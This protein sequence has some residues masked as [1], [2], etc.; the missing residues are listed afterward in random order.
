MLD[1][2]IGFRS[3]F[4]KNTL[5]PSQQPHKKHSTKQDQNQPQG[6]NN[7]PIKGATKL[8]LKKN[9]KSH[10]SRQNSRSTTPNACSN[11]ERQRTERLSNGKTSKRVD[12]NITELN[13]SD[14]DYFFDNFDKMFKIRETPDE[15]SS[16]ST[17]PTKMRNIRRI[18]LDDFA[19]LPSMPFSCKPDPVN[20]ERFSVKIVSTKDKVLPKLEELVLK[21]YPNAKMEIQVPSTTSHM[22]TEDLNNATQE[23][24]EDMAKFELSSKTNKEKLP[25]LK[26]PKS[27]M[28][29][30]SSF[31]KLPN[32][33]TTRIV[34]KINKFHENFITK[35]RVKVSLTSKAVANLDAAIVKGKKSQQALQNLLKS[36]KVEQVRSK[37]LL[38]DENG[39][40]VGPIQ[41]EDV[42]PRGN[43]VQNIDNSTRKHSLQKHDLSLDLGNGSSKVKF[44]LKTLEQRT[45]N[46]YYQGILNKINGLKDPK[47]TNA[48]SRSQYHKENLSIM[49]NS[50]RDK[51]LLEGG[52][53]T[54]K[55]LRD[56]TNLVP[57]QQNNNNDVLG[58][59]KSVKGQ[60]CRVKV[61]DIHVGQL[62]KGSRGSVTNN[63]KEQSKPTK[64][65]RIGVNV[66]NPLKE[67]GNISM[68]SRSTSVPRR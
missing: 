28:N 35:N 18:L 45:S 17:E 5:G 43:S 60:T 13:H 26:L 50:S 67:I 64:N 54:T 38:L 53:L 63:P 20:P 57:Q 24:L 32:E 49:L 68:E 36:K 11:I 51:A 25:N 55:G 27:L 10:T 37:A 58:G 34:D 8:N 46:Y 41:V 3:S 62:Y 52:K 40:E 48:T 29:K 22:I 30:P 31:N 47:S 16:P 59:Q 23:A 4:N 33:A 14:P 9:L 56:S 2:E 61:G 66:C 6:S 1:S 44:I 65:I 39:M 7:S 42:R 19:V 15:E 21:P 12:L